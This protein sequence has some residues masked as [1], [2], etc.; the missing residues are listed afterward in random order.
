FE[1]GASRSEDMQAAREK[2]FLQTAEYFVLSAGE[3]TQTN[4]GGYSE[5]SYASYF[6]RLH[7]NFNNRYLLDGVLRRDGS[8]VF[9]ENNRWGT[10]PSIAGAWVISE[11][12]FMSGINWMD[13]LKLRA[14]WGQS[15]NNRIGTY[16]GFS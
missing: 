3:G 1:T 16:N 5:S 12:Q 9:A 11:E 4:S 2:Y 14:S 10:F 13:F 6:G 7:Y 15:G 8:S